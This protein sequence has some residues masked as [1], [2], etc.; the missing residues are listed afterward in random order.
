[1]MEV[2]LVGQKD[3]YEDDILGLPIMVLQEK[4][5][6]FG[7]PAVCSRKIWA[8]YVT[9]ARQKNETRRRQEYFAL[10]LGY[11]I[12]VDE[13]FA[14]LNQIPWDFASTR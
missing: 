1:M 14:Y 9:I 4:S 10:Y 12:F 3:G 7:L 2:T 8:Q 13:E 11:R 6:I 5:C